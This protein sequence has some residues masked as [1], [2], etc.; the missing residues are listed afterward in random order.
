LFLELAFTLKV[1]PSPIPLSVQD[2][3]K[4]A[5]KQD[6]P[7][8]DTLLPVI[9]DPP[10]CLGRLILTVTLTNPFLGEEVVIETIV[11]ADGFVIF[12]AAGLIGA[13]ARLSPSD[14]AIAI[15][16]NFDMFKA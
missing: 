14:I 11:G 15:D 2:V 16:L 4:F 5:I 9:F 12:A 8:A 13:I 7:S 1:F 3:F 6:L 10:F